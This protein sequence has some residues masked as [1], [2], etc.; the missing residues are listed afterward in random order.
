MATSND[1][2]IP[3]VL[4]VSRNWLVSLCEEHGHIDGY[5]AESLKRIFSGPYF[6]PE[7]YR[8]RDPRR[9][10]TRQTQR[11][12]GR[13]GLYGG[14]QYDGSIFV[15]AEVVLILALIN[16]H[17]EAEARELCQMKLADALTVARD[18]YSQYMTTQAE[19]LG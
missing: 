7:E 8:G 12:I 18:A 16:A 2:I 1:G 4:P 6:G 9:W 3:Q 19:G 5:D 10:S 11:L 14:S 17:G 15:L 13:Y